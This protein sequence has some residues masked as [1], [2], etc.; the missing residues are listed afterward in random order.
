ML[1]AIT[2][3]STVQPNPSQY[4]RISD[5]RLN[6][7][8]WGLV[9]P[10]PRTNI[11]MQGFWVLVGQRMTCSDMMFSGH[12]AFLQICAHFFALYTDYKH[13]VK[14]TSWLIAYTGSFLL[15]VQRYHYT[16]D[17]IISILLNMS[18]VFAY[19]SAVWSYHS[20][21]TVASFGFQWSSPF[22]VFMRLIWWM[23]GLD[24][25]LLNVRDDEAINVA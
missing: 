12:T 24:Y 4:C 7:G 20:Y 6:L 18:L 17:I 16:N 1:R 8:A 13:V 23:D 19:H 25:R 3:V 22:T 15:L 9:G 5:N 10:D 2:V 14:I 11:F 21:K